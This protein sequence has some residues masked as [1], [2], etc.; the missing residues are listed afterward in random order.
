L[1]QITHAELKTDIALTR[2][3]Q[4]D[5]GSGKESEKVGAL[6]GYRIVVDIDALGKALQLFLVLGFALKTTPT[7]DFISKI[8][9]VL[10]RRAVVCVTYLLLS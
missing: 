2:F 9:L 5:I 1:W 4:L 8:V 7:G 10:Y 6:P 3:L